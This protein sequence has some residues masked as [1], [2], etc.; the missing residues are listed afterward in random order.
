MVQT[1][2][3]K[4]TSQVFS[5][6]DFTKVIQPSVYIDAPHIGHVQW[7]IIKPKNYRVTNMLCNCKT[8]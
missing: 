4:V 3:L 8:V 2:D 1:K 6:S 5:E 7:K